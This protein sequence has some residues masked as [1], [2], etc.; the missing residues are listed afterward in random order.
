MRDSNTWNRNCPAS[1]KCS[2][3]LCACLRLFSL[4]SF[5]MGWLKQLL[6]RRRRYDELA[7][8]IR[9]H[10]EEKIDDLMEEGLSREE[11]T[12]RARREFGNATLIEERSR[13]VWQWPRLETFFQDLRFGARM[14]L[15]KPGFTLIALITLAIGIGANTAIFSVVNAALLKPLSY[16]DP[17]R[18]VFLWSA[19]PNGARD[20]LSFQEFNE[21]KEQ[22]EVFERLAADTTQSVNLTG[23]KEP[24]RVRGAFVYANFFETFKIAPL[25]GRTFAKGEDGAGAE[26]VVV[27][28]QSLWQSRLNSDPNLNGKKLILNDQA[29]SVIGVVPASFK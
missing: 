4:R 16:K 8:S 5:S 7:E 27:V 6:S 9:E 26:R 1:K 21:F 19:R 20:G 17:D 24:D 13:E 3:A 25:I 14:F 28:S 10:L 15:K 2:P 11:A 12:R 18:L 23:I 22:S 29:H